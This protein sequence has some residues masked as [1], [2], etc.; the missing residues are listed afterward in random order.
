MGALIPASSP[1][2]GEPVV[3]ER[4]AAQTRPPRRPRRPRF[5][6]LLLS[7]D[8]AGGEGFPEKVWRRENTP[9]LSLLCLAYNSVY[10]ARCHRA[11][12]WCRHGF[13]RAISPVRW[14]LPSSSSF[15]GGVALP[16]VSSLLRKI[17]T[18]CA[19]P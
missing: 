1:T 4:W 11:S 16:V 8:D 5:R 2:R 6:S 9:L 13:R 3:R 12:G 14:I 17:P 10:Q 19:R 18:Q 7:P 15:F